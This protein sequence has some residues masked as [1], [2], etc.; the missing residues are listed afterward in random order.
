MLFSIG[1]NK[2]SFNQYVQKIVLKS[3]LFLHYSKEEKNNRQL[4]PVQI[5]FEENVEFYQRYIHVFSCQ[6]CPC[7]HLY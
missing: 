7:G 1:L 2:F 4:S 5:V 3:N 6:T